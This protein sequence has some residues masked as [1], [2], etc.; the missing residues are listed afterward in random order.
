SRPLRASS[1]RTCDGVRVA[2]GPLMSTRLFRALVVV[3]LA[4]FG[5]LSAG[6]SST[7]NGSA[8]KDLGS[9]GLALQLASGTTLNSVSY[10][11]TG[12]SSFSRVGTIDT[13]QSST[14]SAVIGSLPAGGG[15]SIAL[16]GTTTDGGTHCAGAAP[17]TVAAHMTTAVT[18]HLACHEPAR[19]GSV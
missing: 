3:A 12:P 5:A 18:V 2:T 14:V 7:D 1:R 6:C 16:D 10:T 11:I 13:S 17:F 8:S 19:T 15:Y 9:I 4:S